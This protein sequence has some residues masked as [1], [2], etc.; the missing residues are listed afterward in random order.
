MGKLWTT[1]R[2]NADCKK[3][4]AFSPTGVSIAG[5]VAHNLGQVLCSAVLMRTTSIMWYFFALVISGVIGGCVVG[6]LAAWIL[7]RFEKHVKV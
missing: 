2:W 6:L 4:N 3:A 5:A 1:S 7:R